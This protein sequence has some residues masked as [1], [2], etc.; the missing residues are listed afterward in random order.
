M[1]KKLKC[2]NFFLLLSGCR[3]LV[4]KKLH[5]FSRKICRVQRMTLAIDR[6]QIEDGGWCCPSQK[7]MCAL[8][9]RKWPEDV[10]ARSK[11]GRK[12]MPGPCMHEMG[13]SVRKECDRPPVKPD[14][15]QN[16]HKPARE[17]E[18]D[19]K[20]HYYYYCDSYFTYFFVVVVIVEF[21]IA[22]L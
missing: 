13:G 3:L 21:I 6:N 4:R 22:S 20:L 18:A 5:V 11:K 9:C 1:W 15:D 19:D 7:S 14:T 2:N 10:L 12:E 8:F 17:K 16:V